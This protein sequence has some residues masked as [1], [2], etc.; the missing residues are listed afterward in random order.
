MNLVKYIILILIA[1][2]SSCIKDVDYKLDFEGSKMVIFA[3]G[4]VDQTLGARITRTIPPLTK[5]DN[6]DSLIVD[7]AIVQLY[8]NNNLV[9]TL[10]YIDNGIYQSNIF[11]K[12]EYTYFIKA[13]AE[14]LPSITSGKD[15]VPLGAKILDADINIESVDS[16]GTGEIYVHYNTYV[17]VTKSIK[18]PYNTVWIYLY[19][20]D[21][22]KQLYY[23][24]NSKSNF[25]ECENCYRLLDSPCINKVADNTFELINIVSDYRADYLPEE[26]DSVKFV[27][28][29][30]SSLSEK[31]CL[32][33]VNY[34]ELL[35]NPLPFNSN[36]SVS[37]SNIE[38]GY[39]FFMLGATDTLT[40]KL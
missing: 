29:T 40:V 34:E 38:G 36:P 12:E 2:F 39:G 3:G 23:F 8:E 9:D 37:F 24:L 33:G 5:M 4:G 7:N 19:I 17:K 11:L 25:L 28:A 10:K 1:S 32:N 22:I 35:N 15:I 26:I 27:F 21:R 30:F 20:G 14:N 6:P 18:Y 13:N 31:I 16:F